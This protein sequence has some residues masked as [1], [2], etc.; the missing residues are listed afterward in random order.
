MYIYIYIYMYLRIHFGSSLHA[1]LSPSP[2]DFCFT[3]WTV[4][5]SEVARSLEG[6]F[7]RAEFHKSATLTQCQASKAGPVLTVKN[8][9]RKQSE[10]MKHKS[11][12]ENQAKA[13]TP[14]P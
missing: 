14:K 7:P 2:R 1:S 8:C 9:I 4:S 13:C 6:S 11:M 10:Q 5:H 12:R 3:F